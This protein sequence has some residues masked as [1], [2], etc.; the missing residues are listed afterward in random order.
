[1]SPLDDAPSRR[2]LIAASVNV[3]RNLQ[4]L[5]PRADYREMLASLICRRRFGVVLF[6]SKTTFDDDDCD[7]N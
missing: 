3:G 6:R 7:E 5:A 1:M 2:S 4:S